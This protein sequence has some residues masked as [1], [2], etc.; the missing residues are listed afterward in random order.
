MK[1]ILILCVLILNLWVIIPKQ[2]LSTP[3]I[4]N[5][6][7]LKSDIDVDGILDRKEWALADSITGLYSPWHKPDSDK[8]TF[9][10]FYSENY[11]NFCFNV[12]DKT[13]TTHEFL[14]EL[15]VAKEDRVELFFS[16]NADLNQYFCIEMD[17]LG[18]VLDYSAKYY[19]K[20]NERWNFKG[21]KIA[22]QLTA[23]GYVIEGRILLKELKRMGIKKSFHLGV[24]RADFRNNNPDDVVWYSWIDPQSA[25]P[26]FHIPTAFGIGKFIGN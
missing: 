21:I 11:F 13:I 19:Q 5:I 2:K 23:Q 8:T 3:S 7:S 16:S 17:P 12:L 14:N 6:V 4:F 15:T 25:S 18:Q 26:D 20:F 24:F 22:S 1:S 9:K 10:S